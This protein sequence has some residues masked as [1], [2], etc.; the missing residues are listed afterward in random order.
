M[1]KSFTSKIYVG[2]YAKYASSSIYGKWLDLEDYATKEEFLTACA[3]LHK[4]ET[5]PEYMFQDMEDIPEGMASEGHVSDDL[6]DWMNLEANDRELLYVFRENIDRT[7][8]LEQAH[9]V[10]HGAYDSAADYALEITG[11]IG[12]IP[13][14]LRYYIDYE[15][16]ARDWGYNGTSFVRHD[17]KIWV[18]N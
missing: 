1:T 16:M 11:E 7:G 2:T 18:F 13:E 3:E 12:D 17:G 8:T 14:H 6:F 5:D 10:Y 15:A 4:D 9:D